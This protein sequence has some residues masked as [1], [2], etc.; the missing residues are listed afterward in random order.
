MS[1]LISPDATGF[2]RRKTPQFWRASLA[3]FCGAFV[4]F[5]N[6]YSTQALLPLLAQRFGISPAAA[7]LSLSVATIALAIALLFTP[8]LSDR[9]GRKGVMFSSLALTSCLGF[10]L[11]FTEHYSL[12]LLLR[13]LQGASLA[14]LA[15]IAMTYVNEEFANDCRTLAMGLYVSGTAVGG[16]TGRIITGVL[17]EHYGWVLAL[18]VLAVLSLICTL[19]FA[20]MLPRSQHFCAKAYSRKDFIQGFRYHLKQPAQLGRFMHGFLLMGCLVTLYNYTGFRLSSL[21]YQ[22]SEGQIGWLFSIYL[23]GIFSSTWLGNQ[24]DR[25]GQR[26]VLL[27]TIVMMLCGTLLTFNSKLSLL[28]VGLGLFTF[29]F[30][31]AHSIVSSWTGAAALQYKAQ[32][33]ALYL[34]F[35]YAGS[36]LMGVIGGYFWSHWRWPG[37]AMLVISLLVISGAIA[38][39]SQEQSEKKLEAT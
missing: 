5:A 4:T 19:L 14:G 17:T 25:Y 21:P 11:T 3:L 30:F 27:C 7:S 35:Y 9:L 39:L 31:G 32:A 38:I 22:L 28:I 12:L 23:L 18:Q 36:S 10:A 13:A 24:A 2:I 26:R 15:A 16:M 20:W 34:L 8:S 37:V 6:L 33:S 29:G 1:N